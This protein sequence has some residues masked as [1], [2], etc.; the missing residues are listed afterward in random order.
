MVVKK[1]QDKLRKMGDKNPTLAYAMDKADEL[2]S[3]VSEDELRQAVKDK[4]LNPDSKDKK[5]KIKV[6]RF[7]RKWLKKN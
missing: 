3:S 7:F 6:K 4:G 5:E 1:I 2:V